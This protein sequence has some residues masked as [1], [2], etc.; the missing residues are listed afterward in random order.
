[1]RISWLKESISV[2]FVFKYNKQSSRRLFNVFHIVQS[3]QINVINFIFILKAAVKKN[4][5][6]GTIIGH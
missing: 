1:M 5:L 2:D 6:A 3:L 4:T